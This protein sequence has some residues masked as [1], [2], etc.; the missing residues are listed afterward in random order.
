MKLEKTLDNKAKFFNLYYGQ[1]IAMYKTDQ[2]VKF[3]I[4]DP[5]LNSKHVDSIELKTIS[6]ITFK[7]AREL[8]LVKLETQQYPIHRI[9]KIKYKVDSKKQRRNAVYLTFIVSHEVWPDEVHHILITENTGTAYQIVD[10][11]RSLG[12]YIGDLTEL[13]YG[14]VKLK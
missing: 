3:R 9:T 6:Q 11:A 12:Y 2:T 4:G 1:K 5:K 13:A 8:L 7:D 10:K 14:W